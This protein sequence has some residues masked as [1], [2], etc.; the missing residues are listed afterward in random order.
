LIPLLAGLNEL[1]I[2]LMH[3]TK[4]MPLPDL[5]HPDELEKSNTGM[6]RA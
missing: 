6:Y 3:S 4:D 1:G 2:T 5:N